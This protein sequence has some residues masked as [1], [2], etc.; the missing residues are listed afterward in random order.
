[1]ENKKKRPSFA[2]HEGPLFLSVICER[3]PKAAIAVIKNSLVA[4]ADGFDL[5]IPTLDPKYRN[6]DCI[7]EIVASTDRP[8]LALHYNRDYDGKPLG[9]SDEKR[10]EQLLAAVE[11]GASAVDMQGY[12]FDPDM[13]TALDGA[14]QAF[15]KKSPREVTVRPETV[16]KQ[17]AFIEKVHSLGA[18]VVLSTHTGIMMTA[19]ETVELALMLEKR[20]ADVVKIIGTAGSE[21]DIPECLRTV[22]AL[23]KA[24]KVKF[25]FHL[26][27][28]AGIPTRIMAPA[29]GSYMLFCFEHYTQSSN[30]EQCHLASVVDAFRRLGWK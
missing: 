5:H 27:G 26:G 16:E 29:L 12:T 3:T 6:A 4:G 24:L 30:F 9:E 23:K 28:A 20:G 14:K 1:M 13:A 7:R 2:H 8:I 18:E 15:A 10:M 22:L 19:E 21:D 11:A 25:A 17:C